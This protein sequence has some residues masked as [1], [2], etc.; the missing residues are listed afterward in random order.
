MSSAR[1]CRNLARWRQNRSPSR[2]A[3]SNSKGI[4]SNC[5]SASDRK[6]LRVPPPNSNAAKSVNAVS[7]NW[8]PSAISLNCSEASSPSLVRGNRMAISRI[9]I[10][11]AG[12][13]LR[14]MT[15]RPTS[16]Y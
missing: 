8:P 6:P 13:P 14:I 1:T 10:P 15:S 5:N 7:Q 4:A 2:D 11:I 9:D 12:L 3:D 16:R